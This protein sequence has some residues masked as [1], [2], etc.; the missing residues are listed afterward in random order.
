MC[1]DTHV[2]GIIMEEPEDEA[3]IECLT[4]S[5]QLAGDHQDST[6]DSVDGFQESQVCP[7]KRDVQDCRQVS[8]EPEGREEDW[9][10]CSTSC[11]ALCGVISGKFLGLYVPG[12]LD[13]YKM[14]VL[15]TY[16]TNAPSWNPPLN[17]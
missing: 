13:L 10:T 12:L 9:Q 1:L 15:E 6:I 2:Y 11:Y 7:L 5:M 4:S 3:G 17:I 16:K 14:Y 8:R